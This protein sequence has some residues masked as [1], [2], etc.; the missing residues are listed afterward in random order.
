MSSSLW[1]SR[2]QNKTHWRS[3]LLSEHCRPRTLANANS[4]RER[5]SRTCARFSRRRI[6]P[7]LK[8]PSPR[9]NP[10]TVNKSK[11]ASSCPTR[12]I[13]AK[14]LTR[15]EAKS[16]CLSTWMRSRIARTLPNMVSWL[17]TVF[18]MWCWLFSFQ[19]RWSDEQTLRGT[20]SQ[21]RTCHR[22]LHR[23]GSVVCEFYLI[24]LQLN[25]LSN[26]IMLH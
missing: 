17:V 23:S 24:S 19:S 3:C 25:C 8:I 1:W 18:I 22:H 12:A 10:R 16:F 9:C 11:E 7:L 20:R 14:R 2:S 15:L 21:T 6:W 26:R 5:A 13:W 4:R